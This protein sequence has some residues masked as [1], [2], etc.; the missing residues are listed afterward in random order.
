MKKVIIFGST[1]LVGTYTA[2]DLKQKGFDVVAVGRRKSD[3]GFF[4]ENGIE[5]FSVDLNSKEDFKKLP[6]DY[7]DAIIHFAGAMPAHMIGYDAKVYLD[8]IILGTYN[9]LEYAK[10]VKAERII[11]SQS[12]ADVGYLFGS[13][14]PVP[15][16][17]I[18][19]F[20]KTGDHAVYSIAKNC[21]VNLIE[22][23]SAEYG[24]KPF[25]L[26]L[27]TIYAYHP[28]SWYYVDGKKKK[29]GYRL[30]MEKAMKGEPIEI[31]GNPKNVKELVYIEDFVQL[32]RLCVTSCCNSGIFNAGNDFPMAFEDQIK[33][34]CD[35]LN[36]ASK[37]SEL[38]Y[39]PELPSSPQFIL[40]IEKAKSVLGYRPVFGVRKTFEAFKK[41]AELNRFAKLWGT[42]EDY[43]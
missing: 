28:N 24:I 26:R 42:E 9:I 33:T 39:K 37:K 13:T 4:R 7:I 38:I 31:W 8:S 41:E 34:M 6:T 1:G 16:D 23:Y 19:K 30:L 3:N 36:P 18:M 21:A 22:H 14:K 10:I 27:P 5:Y 17:S 35:V 20:P 40:G 25:I 2:I 11:F 43:K 29:L 15:E 12:I 32:V